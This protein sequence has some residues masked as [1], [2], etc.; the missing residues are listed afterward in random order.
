M[1]VLT[2]LPSWIHRQ[3]YWVHS[4]LKEAIGHTPIERK[5]LAIYLIRIGH[6]EPSTEDLYVT[7]NL[8]PLMDKVIVLNGPLQLTLDKAKGITVRVDEAELRLEPLRRN[9]EYRLNLGVKK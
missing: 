8:V 4:N 2:S 5:N 7:V 6:I 9:E 1:V 3:P